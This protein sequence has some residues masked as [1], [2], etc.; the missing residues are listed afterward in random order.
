MSE[1]TTSIDS[2]GNFPGTPLPD[3]RAFP[4][5]VRCPQCREAFE[6]NS[7]SELSSLI[8]P[9]CRSQVNLTDDSTRSVFPDT[10]IVGQFELV[11]ELGHGGFGTVWLARDLELDRVVAVKIPHPHRMEGD[12][13]KLFFREA[14]AAAHL[15]HPN[16]V[17]V[18]EIGNDNGQVYLVSEFIRGVTL[19]EW[20]TTHSPSF[21][22]ST[23]LCITVAEALHYAH[24]AGIIHR[25]LKPGN[26]LLDH[27][28]QPRIS[29]FGLAKREGGEPTITADGYILGT[30]AYMS[31]EQASGFAHHATRQSDVFSLGVILFEMLT[32][33]KPFRGSAS[34]IIHKVI[35]EDVP[36]LRSLNKSIPI[37]LEAVCIKCLEKHPSSR[38]ETM[39]DLAADLKRFLAGEPVRARRVTRLNRGWRWCKRKPLIST[40]S[41]L[42][43]FV[44]LTGLASTTYLWRLAESSAEDALAALGEA[45]L[46]RRDLRRNLF[47][48]HMELTRQSWMR[49]DIPQM[50]NLLTKYIP[51]TP[52]EED[53]REFVWHLWWGHCQRFSRILDHG[54]HVLSI[55]FSS[56]GRKLAS[57]GNDRAIRIWDIDSGKV[58]S[59][60]HRTHPR[61]IRSLAYSPDGRW[62]ASAGETEV[63]VWNL[64]QG[65]SQA[66]LPG[67]AMTVGFTPDGK[68]LICV[69]REGLVQFV[70]TQSW[71]PSRTAFGKRMAPVA[72][73][74]SADGKHL[75]IANRRGSIFI[76]EFE[77]QAVKEFPAEQLET[78]SALA[79]SPD[80]KLIVA[81][82]E[83]DLRL[84]DADT[85]EVLAT[86]RGHVGPIGTLDFS[87]DGK[88]LVSSCND[89]TV[90]QWS[91][92]N[93]ELLGTMNEHIWSVSNGFVRFSPNGRQIAAAS[94]DGTIKVWGVLD[95]EPKEYVDGHSGSVEAVTF[96]PDNATLIS[97]SG[98]KTIRLWNTDS[99][100]LRSVLK[101][102][103]DAVFDVDCRPDGSVIA[104][105]GNDRTV[106][107]W[108]M[109]AGQLIRT[110]EGHN[111]GVWSV[112]FSPNGKLLASASV[113]R[114]IRVWSAE[115]GEALRVLD[116]H[117]AAVRAVVFLDDETLISGSLDETIRFWDPNTG[118]SFKKLK[119]HAGGVRCL[120][121]SADRKTLASGSQDRTVRLWDLA[122]DETRM[123]LKGL[124]GT[125]NSVAFCADGRTLATGG[126]DRTV[127]LWD[128]YTGETKTYL[129]R[130]AS[131]KQIHSV[132]FSPDGR[133]L[134]A[135]SLDQSI[136]IW[137]TELPA[138]QAAGV[139]SP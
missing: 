115:T 39:A 123:T 41:A 25:D 43:V 139:R 70:D 26:I 74:L 18:H 128:L 112:D 117:E 68:T 102:H 15:Q 48:A 136:R 5:R 64:R 127:R 61:F 126:L 75:A 105:C 122:T 71:E 36:P 44:F 30:P 96:S 13:A 106:R 91:T 23:R 83:G 40:L 133:T 138:S 116:G 120:A 60:F 76:V 57:A 10:R 14:R 21:E 29:D 58:E 129:T 31:P 84:L 59:V 9:A 90:K 37:D 62:V 42:L 6:V 67:G 78:V 50:Q 45:D 100:Q 24:E 79:L 22:D 130:H 16:I 110:L 92:A 137:R 53:L 124:G 34:V 66:S 95:P 86:L 80:A 94:S 107:L 132:A 8:C 81:G 77:T 88:F 38:Y 11:Y 17:S 51:Q 89:G 63:N 27:N 20:L 46:S 32:S 119:G 4:I 114:T 33:V 118:D 12:G 125:V 2:S 93:R 111:S 85:G 35:H 97:G 47:T 28:M 99:G 108:S 103:T 121:I 135:G 82:Y 134:A 49:G 65:E 113:D 87:P 104:S 54:E 7:D 101:G 55:A 52:D 19:G 109:Q 73:A 72:A 69:N 3:T 98:D 56:D 131:A 1:H